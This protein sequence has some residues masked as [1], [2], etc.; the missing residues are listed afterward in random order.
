MLQ[1]QKVIFSLHKN[2]KNKK[3][4]QRKKKGKINDIPK[5]H[6]IE[7]NPRSPRAKL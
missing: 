7:G 6:Q 5:L 1:V 4:T 2:A 3:K